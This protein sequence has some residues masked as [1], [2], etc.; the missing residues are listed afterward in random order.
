MSRS[1]KKNP[2]IKDNNKD[3][4]LAKQHAN[5][6]FRRCIS[7]RELIAGKSG[8]HRKYTESWD[9]HDYVSR[10][11]KA[12]AEADWEHEELLIKSG[13][14]YDKSNI[15]WHRIYRTKERFMNYWAK[16]AKRK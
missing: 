9:I 16:C 1:Y 8:L 12:E 7:E 10:W 11:T 4:K 13:K 6:L 15:L 5:R 14:S 2:I 3:S